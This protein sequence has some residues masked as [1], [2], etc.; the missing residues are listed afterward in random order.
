MDFIFYLLI[1]AVLAMGIRIAH[2]TDKPRKVWDPNKP[3]RPHTWIQ[4]SQS[5]WFCQ[6]CNKMPME[7]RDGDVPDNW[8]RR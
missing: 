7:I 3:C 1:V 4:D 2:D 8:F 6:D 5:N